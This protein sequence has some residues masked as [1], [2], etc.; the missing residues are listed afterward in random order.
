MAPDDT[1]KLLGDAQRS[2]DEEVLDKEDGTVVEGDR[3]DTN[4]TGNP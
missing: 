3:L 2:T 1:G 4:L